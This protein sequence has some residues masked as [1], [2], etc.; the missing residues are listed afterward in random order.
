VC[1]HRV[2]HLPPPLVAHAVE[3]NWA[4]IIDGGGRINGSGTSRSNTN[5]S[6]TSISG[7][8]CGG[9]VRGGVWFL[10]VVY[11]WEPLQVLEVNTLTGEARLVVPDE[12]NTL[13]KDARLVVP[14]EAMTVEMGSGASSKSSSGTGSEPG[15]LSET[16]SGSNS[17]TINGTIN[18]A[19]TETSASDAK[20]LPLLP[21]LPHLH[22][23]L[24]SC[25]YR[26]AAAHGGTQVIPFAGGCLALVHFFLPCF[27]TGR[28]RGGSTRHYYHQFVFFNSA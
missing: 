3:K 12:V 22:L 10:R 26:A 2:L 19:S 14:D 9:V 13:T 1:S 20:L 8:H 7:A 25:L 21:L 15:A 6:T 27:T 16:N 17:G 28:R 18:G 24:G 5:G 11:W 23:I 4:P